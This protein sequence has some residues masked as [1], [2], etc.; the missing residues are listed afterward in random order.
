MYEASQYVEASGL[1]SYGANDADSYRRA[2]WYVD[3]F[4]RRNDK[5]EGWGKQ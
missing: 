1:V 3:K 4:Q 5:C 2:A